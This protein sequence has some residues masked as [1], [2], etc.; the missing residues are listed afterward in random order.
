MKR[1]SLVLQSIAFVL[2]AHGWLAVSG[3]WVS[4]LAA[5]LGPLPASSILPL[6]L[7]M[8][9]GVA[10]LASLCLP[11]RWSGRD[12]W[13]F[14]AGFGVCLGL[15]LVMTVNMKIGLVQAIASL[16][17]GSAGRQEQP[18]SASGRST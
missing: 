13:L 8:V 6:L 15:T 7:A 2:A 12:E 5:V 16:A 4:P 3:T 17:L 11:G 1:T 9:F 10:V 18:R 14:G